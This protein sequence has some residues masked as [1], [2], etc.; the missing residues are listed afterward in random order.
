[1]IEWK[2]MFDTAVLPE[3]S[4]VMN[5]FVRLKSAV[6]A[7]LFLGIALGASGVCGLRVN[8]EEEASAA[9]WRLYQ[10]R[11]HMHL[12]T[13]DENEKQTLLGSG[14]RDE[15][16]GWFA[17]ADG[18]PVWRLYDPQSGDHLYT[19]D[20]TEAAVLSERGWTPEGICW[21]SAGEEGIPV[22]R[23]FTSALTVGSHHFSA[24]PAEQEALAASGAWKPEG[25]GWYAVGMPVPKEPSA[26]DEPEDD[27]PEDNPAGDNLWDNP[28]ADWTTLTDSDW[29]YIKAKVYVDEVT[30]PDMTKEE[31]LRACFDS[32]ANLRERNPWIPHDTSPVWPQRYANSLFDTRSGNCISYAAAFG[33][34]ARVIG[35]EEVYVCNSGGHGWT[36]IDG[37]VYDPE[38]RLHNT[39]ST[40]YGITYFEQTRVNYL[41]V[42]LSGRPNVRM[43]I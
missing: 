8:A 38:W 37:L 19:M 36:E 25:T 18:A 9:V 7:V 27:D 22:Q 30:T 21:Y 11:S 15:G 33:Y 23:W 2:R 3:K 26:E 16:I 6:L 39:D 40:Y 43:K 31:K 35:Y 1:M 4:C 41:G 10:P 29:A 24:D 12:Y 20:E 5:R 42:V 28:P 34:M 14:W 13:Q 17:P 32:F